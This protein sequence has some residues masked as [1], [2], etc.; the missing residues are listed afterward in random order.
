LVDICEG[1][2]TRARRNDVALVSYILKRC[3]PNEPSPFFA[4]VANLPVLL[5]GG[6]FPSDLDEIKA[7]NNK[8]MKQL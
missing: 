6:R 2:F 1:C 7:C 3:I 4:A 8:I 5:G